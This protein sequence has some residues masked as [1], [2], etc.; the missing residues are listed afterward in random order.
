MQI[1]E[2]T[3][4]LE[5]LAPPS[6]QENYD[7]VGLITGSLAWECTGCIISLDATEEVILEAKEKGYNLVVAHHPIIFN[8]LKRSTE[9][10][11]LKKPSL[12]PLSMILPFMP[13]T[14]TLII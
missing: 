7:N 10:H 8:G 11:M 14:Q 6:L 13:S 2:I 3:R 12:H 9:I 1:S 5:T 4:F